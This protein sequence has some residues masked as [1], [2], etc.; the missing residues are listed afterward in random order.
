MLIFNLLILDSAV[1]YYFYRQFISGDKNISDINNNQTDII[2]DIEQG[3]LECTDVCKNEIEKQIE[4][5]LALS[6][7]YQPTTTTSVIPSQAKT[8]AKF[9]SYIPIP[10]SGSTLSTNWIDMAGT[11]F[12]FT[13]S[14]YPGY[15]ESYLEVNMKLINSNGTG[16]IRLY[17]VTNARAVD[18]SEVTT[19]SSVSIFVGSK[20]LSIWEGYNHYRIQAKSL[21]A[22]TTVF[23]SGRIKVISQN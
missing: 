17:D 14:D 10:G 23:E 6:D 9:T 11:D 13:K 19:S 3:D 18:G 15:I 2:D 4:N 22:D 7:K 1:G 12:Y 8:K 5:A 21:T 16:Y 20:N